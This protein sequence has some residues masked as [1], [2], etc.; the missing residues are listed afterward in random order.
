LLPAPRSL[1]PASARRSLLITGGAGF[2]GSHFVRLCLQQ[3]FEVL[4]VDKLTYAGNLQALEEAERNSK[5]HFFQIDIVDSKAL[6]LVFEQ[7]EPTA[8]VHIAAES[9]VDRSIDAP[10]IFVETNIVGTFNLLQESR[11]YFESLDNERKNKFRF[12]QCST[13]EVFGSLGP[14]ESAFQESSRYDPHSPYSASKAAADHL[15]RAWQTTY[16]LPVIV[17]HSSNNYG[18]YQYP[19]KLIPVVITQALAGQTIP[20]YGSGQQV[21]DWIHVD[22]HCEA[23]AVVLES[24]RV[25]ESYNIGANQELTNE[26]LV[27]TIC[28]LLDEIKPRDDGQP[29]AVQITFVADRPGHDQRYALDADKIRTELGWQPRHRVND[30]LRETVRWYSQNIAWCESVLRKSHASKSNSRQ[31]FVS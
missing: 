7:H 9:H 20:I 26:Y 14:A 28:N 11:R 17:T 31:V 25:G 15:A 24:G 2:I 5:H 4:N 6:R 16:G 8:V 13:D 21:R 3:G 22:D 19:E 27:R 12:V 1:P 30:S 10:A 18:S 23:L 29:Y